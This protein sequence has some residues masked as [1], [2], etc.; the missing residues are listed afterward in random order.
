MNLAETRV[1][2]LVVFTVDATEERLLL[3]A[4]RAPRA[5]S[6]FDGHMWAHNTA[7][8]QVMEVVAKAEDLSPLRWSWGSPAI[9]KFWAAGHHTLYPDD[10]E[11]YVPP[12]IAVEQLDRWAQILGLPREIPP[13]ESPGHR[14]Y[15]GIW[16]GREIYL[17]AV[18]DLPAL[19]TPIAQV[20]VE[21]DRVVY[22]AM[23][24]TR[25]PAVPCP[26]CD[27]DDRNYG[28]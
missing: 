8:R 3:A 5:R 22:A 27:L 2:G 23:R 28:S 6:E 14:S 24:E 11:N 9:H 16:Q 19:H 10:H 25:T 17:E 21:V 26:V 12:E 4:L 1:G 13:V 15:R 18:I 20:A 7:V